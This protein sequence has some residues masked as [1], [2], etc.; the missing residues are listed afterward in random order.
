MDLQQR[1]ALVLAAEKTVTGEAPYYLTSINNPDV[2]GGVIAGRVFDIP[3]SK[4]NREPPTRLAARLIAGCTHRL[5][6]PEEIEQFHATLK[7]QTEEL[8]A[9]RQEAKAQFALPDDLKAL[10]KTAAMIIER[11]AVTQSKPTHTK[12]K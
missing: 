1:F 7:R 12:E 9:Q 2:G 4:A 5:S 10:V 6:T 11:E 3:A 8:A